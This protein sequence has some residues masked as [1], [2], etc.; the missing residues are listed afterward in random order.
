MLMLSDFYFSKEKRE[1]WSVRCGSA[2]RD[3]RNEWYFVG[4]GKKWPVKVS[5]GPTLDFPK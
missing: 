5:V 1:L 4:P 3:A 2:G